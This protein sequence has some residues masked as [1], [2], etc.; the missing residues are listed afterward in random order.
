[1]KNVNVDIKSNLEI[2]GHLR[3]TAADHDDVED[4][5]CRSRS[6][7][8]CGCA[9]L[10][11]RYSHHAGGIDERRLSFVPPQSTATTRSPVPSLALRLDELPIPAIKGEQ[12]VVGPHLGDPAVIEHHD[13][14]RRT[15]GR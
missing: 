13:A 3:E 7:A 2:G 14:I 4:C 10:D 9:P 15:D 6:S 11:G 1:M 5:P 8:D 12:L